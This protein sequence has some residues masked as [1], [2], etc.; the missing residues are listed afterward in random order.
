MD[1]GLRVSTC[2]I[3]YPVLSPSPRRVKAAFTGRWDHMNGGVG[4]WKLKDSHVLNVGP[5]LLNCWGEKTR[6]LSLCR[7]WTLSKVLKWALRSFI[8]SVRQEIQ[9]VKQ[10]CGTLDIYKIGK[11]VKWLMVSWNR[12]DWGNSTLKLLSNNNVCNINH[13]K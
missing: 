2:S 10:A 1:G 11:A 9:N 5:F 7:H 13:F 12:A 8:Y 6:T 3:F 4:L